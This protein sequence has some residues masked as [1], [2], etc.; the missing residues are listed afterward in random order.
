[1]SH[2]AQATCAEWASTMQAVTG[3]PIAFKYQDHEHFLVS[4]GKYGM[5]RPAAA[6]VLGLWERISTVGDALPTKAA[7]HLLARPTTDLATWTKAHACCF[8]P[9]FETCPHPHPP[10]QHMF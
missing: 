6:Q 8:S 10:V 3:R 1:M 5:R 9:G 7:E 4:L 2:H